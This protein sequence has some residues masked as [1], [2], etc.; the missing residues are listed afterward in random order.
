MPNIDN[1]HPPFRD[2]SRFVENI[3]RMIVKL[4]GWD[5]D[6]WDLPLDSKRVIVT[7][8]PHT[9]NLDSILMII[10]VASMGRRLRWVVKKELAW[11][12]L[13][14][15][16]RATGGIFIDR[17]SRS[18]LVGQIAEIVKSSESIFLAISPEGTRSYTDKW[19]SGFYYIAVDAGAPIV[20]AH[21]DYKRKTFGAQA[22]FMPSGDLKADEVRIHEYYAQWG[23]ARYPEKFGPI[24]LDVPRTRRADRHANKTVTS[25][26]DAN[27]TETPSHDSTE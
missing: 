19:K 22:P 16:I 9:S 23:A 27:K 13:G 24:V 11:E 5:V 14:T 21:L 8:V 10:F 15:L 6:F 26:T 4:I 17:R 12:P 25:V 3:A 18:G 1:I 2:N 20:L 7:A